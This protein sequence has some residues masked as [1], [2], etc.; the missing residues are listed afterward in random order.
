[1]N[2]RELIEKIKKLLALSDSSNPNE[3]AIALSRAQKLM[4]KYKIESA[5][6]NLG[7]DIGE[8]M[9]KPLS[10]LTTQTSM[11][12][13]LSILKKA[14]GID[15]VLHTA[16][17]KVQT[18]S[19]IGPSDLLECCEYIFTVLSRQAAAAI[20]NYTSTIEC[21][22]LVDTF[23]TPILLLSIEQ[24][25][26]VFYRIALEPFV[27]SVQILSEK[28]DLP[29]TKVDFNYLKKISK[30]FKDA[31]NE[32]YKHLPDWRVTELKRIFSSK[33]KEKKNAFILGYFKSIE[34]KIS[35][36]ALT[37]KMENSITAYISHNYPDLAQTR[38]HY[39]SS[40][41]AALD[42]YQKG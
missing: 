41:R 16:N 9:L 34:K 38:K 39:I 36:Y 40:S 15:S 37:E 12:L 28:T 23:K 22:V 3:A 30:S 25:V 11:N 27:M 17:S 8:I 29:E 14:F 2:K 6:L 31:R 20:G 42:A 1:M 32:A 19:L 13:L 10:A 26:P 21:E 35:E 5:D 4:E 24:H 7:S 33:V 18:V